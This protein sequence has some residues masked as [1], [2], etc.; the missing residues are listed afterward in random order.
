MNKK[1][2]AVAVA[3]ALAVPAA[4]ALAQ[5]S[6]V[7]VG[8]SINVL[9]YQHS[10]NNASVAKKGDILE[11]SEPQLFFRGE[12]K[13]GG[14][15]SVWFQC[16]SS[17]DGMISGAGSAQGW[18]ARNSGI[19]L[20]GSF[21][22][23]WF[24]NWDMPMKL[25]INQVRGWFSGTNAL[26]GGSA[27]LLESGSSSAL[28]NVGSSFYRRQARSIN[29]HSPR[30]SGFQVQAAYS[31]ASETTG[32][33]EAVPLKPRLYS[34]GGHFT[35][36][37]MWVGVG[38]ERHNDYNPGGVAIGAGASAYNGGSDDAWTIGA[39]YTFA[40][41][42]RLA[43]RYTKADYETTN[44]GNLDTDG[45]SVHAD[46][47]VQGPH[48]IKA[49]YSKQDDPGGNTSVSV[50]R[51][52]GSQ[53]AAALAGMGRGADHWTLA[54]TYD[55]SKRTRGVVAYNKI[56]NDNGSRQSLGKTL[57][58]VG[59]SQKTIGIGMQHRF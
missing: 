26:W 6:T 18:C 58:T 22:N 23:V 30:W 38:Y 43:G 55:F 41:V 21:G 34:L 29:W 46:W 48:S 49:Q 32:I 25:V 10:P 54:Y 52:V 31:S 12:E 45:F 7:Q 20:K 53:S 42:F 19:G 24:G 40:G 17:M 39:R 51:Y 5:T 28:G 27:R 35:S 50:N 37:P 44:A 4:A 36:G 15:T 14:G 33:P 8:G 11:P 57:A 9:Y 2:M 1:V 47:R 3:G 59:G 56:N 13:L 16:T